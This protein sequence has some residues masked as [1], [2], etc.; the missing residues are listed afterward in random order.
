MTIKPS[1]IVVLSNKLN[2][3]LLGV[4]SRLEYTFLSVTVHEILLYYFSLPTLINDAR[5]EIVSQC[6]FHIN[7][8]KHFFHWM[9]II[10]WEAKMLRPFFGIPQIHSNM[11]TGNSQ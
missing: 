5:F 11:L 7:Q 3:L 9:A 1:A 10:P 8:Y 4:E 6:Q 2:S